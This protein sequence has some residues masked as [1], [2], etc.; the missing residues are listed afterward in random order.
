M[1]NIC[2]ADL[3][4]LKE[5]YSDE[6]LESLK[7]SI[8][9]GYP[10]QY[11]IGNVCFY[12][13]EIIVNED[14]LIPRYETE[15]LVDLIKNKLDTSKC[16]KMIDI[17][18]GSGCISISLAKLF[19]SSIITGIDISKKALSIAE[20]NKKEN[21]VNNL[22]LINISIEEVDDFTDYD[23]VISNPPYVSENEVVGTETKYEPQNAIFAPNN[24]LYFYEEILKKVSISNKNL[25]IFFEI[26]MNQ[27]EE[28]RNIS[29][30]YLKNF[31]FEVYKD[32]AGKDRYIHIVNKK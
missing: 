13:N 28:I 16:Y 22:E 4:A 9:Q 12:G 32:L 23:I 11:L 31:K 30:K 21:N 20:L 29:E 10:V 17:G 27:A 15:F 3:K 14:V 7:S 19:K 5:K 1:N 24:G 18:T 8:E 26:G 25:E 2:D 6:E